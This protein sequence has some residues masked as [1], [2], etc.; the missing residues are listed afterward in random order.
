MAAPQYPRVAQAQKFAKDAQKKIADDAARDWERSV[1][2]YGDVFRIGFADMLNNGKE[3]W[4]AF[5]KSLATTFK[6]TVADQLYKMFAQPIV[7]NMVANLAGLMGGAAA[8]G[9]V[10]GALDSRAGQ[11]GSFGGLGLMNVLSVARTAY[12]ALTGGITASLASGVSAIGS[13]I[14]STAATWNS[15][16][17]GMPPWCR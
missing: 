15:R 7:V 13:A 10:G 14:G 6:T 17:F 1:D 2:K 16:R 5:T 12:G 9:G 8:A 11:N 4:K 3:G